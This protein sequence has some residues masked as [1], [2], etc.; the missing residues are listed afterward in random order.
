MNLHASGPS[1]PA[2]EDVR[3][4]AMA[5]VEWARG[6]PLL[7]GGDLNVSPAEGNVYDEL[8]ER[9]GLGI[10]TAPTAIDHL[11]GHGLEIVA[12][13]TAWPPEAREVPDDGLALRL[14][15]HAPVQARFGLPAE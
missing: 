10:P 8:A 14:S 7:L 3:R 11:L 9:Y 6:E 15:D 12:P 5:A 2:A 1:V 4:A 13:P